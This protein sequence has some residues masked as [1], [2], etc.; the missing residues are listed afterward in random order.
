MEWEILNK[1][2]LFIFMMNSTILG[3]Y[4]VP[5]YIR[6]NEEES[7][8][9]LIRNY[10]LYSVFLNFLLL[11][12]IIV[13]YPSFLRYVLGIN[14][15]IG[16]N[17]VLLYCLGECLHGISWIYLSSLTARRKI[18]MFWF[19]EGL[20]RLFILVMCV[21]LIPILSVNVFYIIYAIS[22]L[23]LLIALSHLINKRIFKKFEG[24]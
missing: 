20:F 14:P 17:Y 8:K 5:E 22:S 10:L 2:A 3:M 4:F 13:S 9:L 15:L 1:I 24:V 12:I 11:V 6:T 19:F 16:L 21:T 18:L 7:R 23:G